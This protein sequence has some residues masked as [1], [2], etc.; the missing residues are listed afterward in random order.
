MAG[1]QLSPREFKR[2]LNDNG[3]TLQRAKGSHFIYSNG[4]QTISVPSVKLNGLL[5]QRL[6]K[7]NN[8]VVI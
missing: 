7:E 2:I 8:L 3:F 4:I 6:I 5:A 1:K